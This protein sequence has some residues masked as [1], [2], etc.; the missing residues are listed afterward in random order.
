MSIHFKHNPFRDVAHLDPRL[1]AGQAQDV[2]HFIVA[3]EIHLLHAL[4][5]AIL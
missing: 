4:S 3:I 5:A 1:D 2:H